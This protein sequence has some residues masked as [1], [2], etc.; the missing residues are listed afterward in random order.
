MSRASL[1]ERFAN[2]GFHS[3]YGRRYLSAFLLWPAV[4]KPVSLEAAAAVVEAAGNPAEA[5]A[6]GNPAA[7]VPQLKLLGLLMAV[8]FRVDTAMEADMEADTVADTFKKKLSR[9]WKCKEV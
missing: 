7:V 8:P 9:S 2:F 4:P 3:S 1:S 6:A 5:A